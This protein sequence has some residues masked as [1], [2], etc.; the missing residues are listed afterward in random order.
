MN[1]CLCL[2]IHLGHL[3]VTLPAIPLGKEVKTSGR[4]ETTLYYIETTTRVHPSLSLSLSLSLSGGANTQATVRD[5]EHSFSV[6]STQGV[7]RTTLSRQFPQ[8][9]ACM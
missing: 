3:L 2:C 9:V 4:S 1:I 7:R 5:T 8:V 6:F